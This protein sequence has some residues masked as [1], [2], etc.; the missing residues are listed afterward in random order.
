MQ[1]PA[2]KRLKFVS[3]RMSSIRSDTKISLPCCYSSECAFPYKDKSGDK[4]QFLRE[5][6]DET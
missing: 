1:V 3:D 5:I 4:I 2:F 6:R